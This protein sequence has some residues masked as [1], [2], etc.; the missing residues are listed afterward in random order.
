VD[1]PL[2]KETVPRKNGRLTAKEATKR[3][4]VGRPKGAKNKTTIFKEVMRNGFEEEMEREGIAVIKSVI[5]AAKGSP[6]VDKEGN[7]VL[8]D[9]GKAVLGKGDMQAAKLLLDR[10]LPTTKAIDLDQL[11]NSKG[12]TISI[13]VGEL[14][15]HP[16]LIDNN[17]IDE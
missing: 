17:V 6:L 10:I 4:P 5:S 15:G 14:T 13:N 9:Y 8:D 12:L 11:E 16:D 1:K 7:A 2:K 3:L